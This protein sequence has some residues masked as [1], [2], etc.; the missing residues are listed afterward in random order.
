MRLLCFFAVN[1]ICSCSAFSLSYYLNNGTLNADDIYTTAVGNNTNDGFNGKSADKPMLTFRALWNAFGPFADG[2]IIYVDAG[3]YTS[4]AAAGFTNYGYTIT[5]NIT[6]QGVSNTKTIFSNNGIVIS[7]TSLFADVSGTSGAGCVINDIQFTK[8]GSSTDGQCFTVGNSVVAFNRVLMNTNGGSSMYAA[9]AINSNSTVTITGGGINCN[10]N[11]SYPASGGIDVKGTSITLNVTNTSFIGNYK[12]S[13]AQVGNGAGLS[14][15]GASNA[16]TDVNFTNCLFSG[17][18]LDHSSSSGGTIYMTGG[19]LTLTDCIIDDSDMLAGGGGARYGGAFYATGGTAVFTRVKISNCNTTGSS[20]YGTVSVHGGS[21]TMANCYLTGNTSDRGNDIYCKSGSITATNT[22]F[23]S[24]A[25]QTA[26]YGG[27]ITITNC[28]TPTD[29]Y[30]TGTFTNNGGSAP[31]FTTPTTP[32]FTGTC[33]TA[34]SLLPVELLSFT[35]EKQK[36][37]TVNVNWSTLTEKNNDYFIIKKSIDGI[38]WKEIAREKGAGVSLSQIDYSINDRSEMA[39][40]VYY[41]LTQVDFDGKFTVADLISVAYREVDAAK[42]DIV[43]KTNILGQ[44]VND[45]YRGLV[46][47]IYSNGSSEKAIQ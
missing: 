33:A 22:T 37:N 38:E 7:G 43:L 14:I 4:S 46:I 1:L 29:Q 9:L 6:I 41:E 10:G 19:D 15:T 5:K 31:A 24:A 21:L 47:I 16:T 17:C 11:A 39:E 2:D 28:G 30:S 26:T 18:I 8:Y 36:N 32:T 34:V 23:G 13:A 44:E 27:T 45:L 12:A 35:A 3:T 40:I 20:C 25:N 42:G